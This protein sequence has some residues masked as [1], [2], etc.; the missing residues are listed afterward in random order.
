[1]TIGRAAEALPLFDEALRIG[2]LTQQPD[3]I[4]RLTVRVNRAGALSQLGRRADADGEFASA[5]EAIGKRTVEI[6]NWLA[7]V[8]RRSAHPANP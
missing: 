8:K 1:M 5:L 7:S 2:R 4:D 6:Q 3:H